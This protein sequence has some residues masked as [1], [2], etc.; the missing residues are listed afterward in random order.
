MLADAILA[1]I[2]S[3]EIMLAD[4]ILALITAD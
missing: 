2:I 3:K 4:A 1:L